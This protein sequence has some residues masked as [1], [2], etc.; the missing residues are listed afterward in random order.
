[1]IDIIKRI[2][3]ENHAIP[4]VIL[5]TPLAGETVD[6]GMGVEHSLSKYALIFKYN[7]GY[8]MFNSDL[9]HSFYKIENISIA[10]FDVE[11]LESLDGM[12]Q[13]LYDVDKYQVVWRDEKYKEPSKYKSKWYRDAIAIEMSLTKQYSLKVTFDEIRRYCSDKS[14]G[15]AYKGDLFKDFLRDHE[16]FDDVV[17]NRT[18]PGDSAHL[19]DMHF[20]EDG[21]VF[22]FQCKDSGNACYTEEEYSDEELSGMIKKFEKPNSS[23]YNKLSSGFKE[24]FEDI[25]NDGKETECG[26]NT[27]R[28]SIS[29]LSLGRKR[30]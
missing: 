20:C 24:H 23:N 11:N 25:A 29:K 13:E 26:K 19:Q 6:N 30:V 10:Q 18:Y 2:C 14:C 22:V 21:V 15:Y 3:E 27:N 1:M 4:I 16:Y 17:A 5:E 9:S 7:K 8:S 12:I 28:S